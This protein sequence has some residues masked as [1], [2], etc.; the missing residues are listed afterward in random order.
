MDTMA[1]T[2]GI[3]NRLLQ[4]ELPAADVRERSEGRRQ[5][6]DDGASRI[7]TAVDERPAAG[8]ELLSFDRREG[9]KVA[10][11]RDSAGGGV[12]VPFSFDEAAAGYLMERWIEGVHQRR[13]PEPLLNGFYKVKRAIPRSLQLE[14]RRAMISWQRTPAFPRWPLDD[15]FVRLAS[16]FA[17]TW[18]TAARIE[19]ASFRWFWPEGRRSAFILTHDVEG[20]D[21]VSGGCSTSPIWRRA[22]VSGRRSTSGRGTRSTR[23]WS[24]SSARADSS[25]ACTVFG[26]T[27]RSSCRKRRSP[28][29]ATVLPSCATV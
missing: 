21:G 10:I 17:A 12:S 28:G 9:G 24:R 16:I 8:D 18:L 19:S 3:L 4:I 26:T 23:G 27:A 1:G 14:A 7:Y 11:R 29:R 22:S 6:L 13:L 20:P 15:S 5:W 2:G 25:S